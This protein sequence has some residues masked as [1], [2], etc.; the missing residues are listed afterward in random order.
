MEFPLTIKSV[1][2]I[3]IRL[4][5]ERWNHIIK[6]HREVK[7]H[8]RKILITV[9]EP[10]FIVEGKTGAVIAIKRFSKLKPNYVIVAYK[11]TNHDGFIITA[12]F[13][14]NIE[15]VKRRRIIWQRS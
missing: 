7:K 2:D 13:I 1:R 15:Q 12:H 8:I 3:E 4:T 9:K 5:E 10:D 14:S 6:R 11:E